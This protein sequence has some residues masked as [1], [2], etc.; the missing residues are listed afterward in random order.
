MAQRSERGSSR[1]GVIIAISIIAVAA[2]G[3]YAYSGSIPE[4]T[5]SIEVDMP[6]LVPPDA[7]LPEPPAPVLPP[8]A[9]QPG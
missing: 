7:D 1:S 5:A 2:L 3:Y 6:D 9:E 8:T 4:Q